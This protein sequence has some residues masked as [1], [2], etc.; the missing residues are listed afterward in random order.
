MKVCMLAYAHYLNDARIKCYVRTLE[1][2]GHR[3]DVIALK[4]NGESAR[5]VRPTGTIFRAMKKYQGQ[6][7]LMYAWSYLIFFL[8]ALFMLARSSFRDRYEA[9]HVHNMPNALVFAAV[10][11][12]LFGARLILDVHDL[13]T[14]NYMAKFDARESD[15]PVRILKIEQRLSSMFVDHVFCADHNQ[16]DYLVNHCGVSRKK[17]TVL[18]NLPNA[19]LFGSITREKEK[20]SETF[21]IVYHGT[22]A[23]RLGIDL[24][25]QAMARVAAR[26]PAELWMYGA[27]DYLPEA[28]AL[29]SELG[30]GERV[31]FSRAFFP[32]EQI[33]EIVCGMDLGV[34]GNRRNLACDKYMLPVKL[35]EY[36]YL[37]VPVVAPRLD[38]IARYF[39]DTMLRYYEPEN[40]EQLADAIVELFHDRKERER[41]AQA[42]LMFYEQH[43]IE[44]QANRYLDL[45]TARSVNLCALPEHH[46]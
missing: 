18:M 46:T 11:P 3:V 33:P 5:E 9:V 1:D 2:H 30:L 23:H 45:L 34:I 32:V 38:V 10:I 26:V 44:A 21:R 14:V 8:K 15:L 6:S 39:D 43:N 41:L 27:G 4:S 19:E 16:R 28:I 42:A 25:L 24:I 40:V 13:M 20:K 7:T 12:K 36:V 37:N 22:M 35:L 31:H 29:S 17:I